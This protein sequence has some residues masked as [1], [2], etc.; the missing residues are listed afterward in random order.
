[1]QEI[2]QKEMQAYIN[3]PDS[4]LT[5]SELYYWASI[6]IHEE[7]YANRSFQSDYFDMYDIVNPWEINGHLV[8]HK[9]KKIFDSFPKYMKEYKATF[10]NLP[11]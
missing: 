5:L 11:T 9:I 3:R 7:V 2:T 4:Q 8:Y 1:M 10:V 6:L